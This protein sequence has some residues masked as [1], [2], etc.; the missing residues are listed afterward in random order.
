M[1]E[2][3][4]TLREATFFVEQK[5]AEGFLAEIQ[6]ENVAQLWGPLAAG[7][8][9]VWVSDERIDPDDELDPE[10]LSATAAESIDSGAADQ[11]IR[12]IV[13][14]FL[15]LGALSLVANLLFH[16]VRG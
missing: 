6:N 9:R 4:S 8:Y 12:I 16:L 14:G 7:G 15:L 10:D 11:W 2:K 5:R 13:I 1:I 3:F